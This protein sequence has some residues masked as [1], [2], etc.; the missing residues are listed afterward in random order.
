[1]TMRRRGLFSW[2]LGLML[3]A[4]GWLPVAGT[5]RV[6]AA[7]AV[8]VDAAIGHKAIG[9]GLWPAHAAAPPT[10]P[11]VPRQQSDA[12]VARKSAGCLTCHKPDSPSMHTKAKAIG[13]TDCHGGDSTAMAPSGADRTS[14]AFR[15]VKKQA[16]VQ[17]KLDIWKTSANPVRSAAQ[18]LQESLDFIRFVNPGDLRFVDQTCAPCHLTEVP[19]A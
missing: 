6:A 7:G 17:P 1:M 14:G 13:C 19:N 16:H 11:Q 3:L 10:A 15:D 12:A 4:L 18:V 9:V 5:S 2:R 8:P